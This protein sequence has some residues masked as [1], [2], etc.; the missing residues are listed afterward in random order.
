MRF[1]YFFLNFLDFTLWVNLPEG[2]TKKSMC[3]I[4]SLFSCLST[5]ARFI[6]LQ[7]SSCSY[8]KLG[9]SRQLHVV[10]HSNIMLPYNYGQIVSN[11]QRNFIKKK[12]RSLIGHII[13][14]HFLFEIG[15]GLAYYS[16]FW[17]WV[18][19]KLSN[20]ILCH[21]FSSVKYF[22]YFF[23]FFVCILVYAKII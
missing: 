12:N 8:N 1:F 16:Y 7:R 2:P 3:T 21:L 9:C 18:A 20:P 10:G 22:I 17:D 5:A 15:E 6:H 4:M 13:I 23:F 19:N 11:S 14:R